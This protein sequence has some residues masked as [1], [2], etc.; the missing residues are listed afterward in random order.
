M[1]V[2]TL[3][4]G[5]QRSFERPVTVAEIATSIGK[6]LARAALAG[7]VDGRLV[8]TSHV[9]DRDARLRIITSKDPEGLDTIRATVEAAGGRIGVIACGALDAG[10]IARVTDATGATELHFAAL[11]AEPSGMRYRNPRVGMGGT[12]L[13]REYTNTVTDEEAVRAT[14]AAARSGST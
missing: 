2:V 12:A 11:R 10:N 7:E 13:E 3:P 4:D 6:G 5:S 8:D 1:P 14:I 9:V